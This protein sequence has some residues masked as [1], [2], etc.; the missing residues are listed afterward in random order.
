MKDAT[1]TQKMHKAI[2]ALLVEPTVG[3]AAVKAG[4]GERTLRVWLKREDFRAAYRETAKQFLEQTLHRLQADSGRAADVLR[5]GMAADQPMALRIRAAVELLS[6]S[7]KAVEALDQEERLAALE[8][9]VKQAQ[10]VKVP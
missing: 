4:I 1:I 6:H 2:D 10:G 7:E 3:K 5:E 8:A 9:I